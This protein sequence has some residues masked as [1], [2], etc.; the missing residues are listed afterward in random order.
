MRTWIFFLAFI[1]ALPCVARDVYKWKS[2]DGVI[3]YSD[4]YQ[5][6]AERVS[7]S[8]GK[9]HQTETNNVVE[10]TTN[11]QPDTVSGVYQAFEIAQPQNDLSIRSDEGT[12]NVGLSLSPML[13]AGHI[14]QVYLDGTKFDTDLTTTQFSLNGLNRGTHTLQAKVVDAKGNPQ[15]STQSISFQLRKAAVDNP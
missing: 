11:E 2:E 10:S 3:I 15:I 14:I 9:A 12:V 7:I 1:I 5:N 6:G 13:Q 8:P 4:T